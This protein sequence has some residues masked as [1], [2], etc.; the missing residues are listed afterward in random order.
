MH[1]N[2]AKKK[3]GSKIDRHASLGEGLI[4]LDAFKFIM[5]DSRF[6]E[7]PLIL[8]TPEPE[9]WQDEIEMLYKFAKE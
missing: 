6:E 7:I 8:E 1:L 9:I 5:R 3:L 4:G 2:D